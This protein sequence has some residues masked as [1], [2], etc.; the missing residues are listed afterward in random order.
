MFTV[1]NWA[2]M[3]EYSHM[4]HEERL[5]AA[6]HNCL[7]RELAQTRPPLQGARKLLSRML[8]FL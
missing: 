2:N 8:F 4:L 6:R 3:W 7:I 5:A 1:N